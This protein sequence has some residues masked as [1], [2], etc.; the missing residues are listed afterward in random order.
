MDYYLLQILDKEQI[1]KH[2]NSECHVKFLNYI[3][4][5]GM[6]VNNKIKNNPNCNFD[7]TLKCFESWS[8]SGCTFCQTENV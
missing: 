2:Q 5:V 3:I 1:G 6:K 8:H 7:S 4:K